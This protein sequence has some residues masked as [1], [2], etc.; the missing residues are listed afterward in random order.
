MAKIQCRICTSPFVREINQA[1]KDNIENYYIIKNFWPLFE[2]MKIYNSEH[3]M[4]ASLS[5]HFTGKHQNRKEITDLDL[6]YMTPEV[7][8]EF[9][10]SR[11]PQ[12]IPADLYPKPRY[13]TIVKEGKDKDFDEYARTLL[14]YG[15]S[16][17]MLSSKKVSPT[18]IIAA[19]KTL[20][21]REKIKKENSVI[22]EVMKKLMS[23]MVTKE[24]E[25][26]VSKELEGESHASAT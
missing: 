19:Q 8:Q 15:F 6:S 7:K 26:R 14:E 24:D 11:K 9:I 10:D 25:V 4:K 16:P 12:E 5:Y 1:R 18:M 17:E 20:L 2:R 22:M 21:E 3:T 13:Q 23:G